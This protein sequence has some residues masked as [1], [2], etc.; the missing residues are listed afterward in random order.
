[1]KYMFFQRQPS[2]DSRFVVRLAMPKMQLL[3]GGV[4]VVEGDMELW[5]LMV[6][7]GKCW[8]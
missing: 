4:L 5:T 1:M 8:I 3:R 2:N 7:V 6:F